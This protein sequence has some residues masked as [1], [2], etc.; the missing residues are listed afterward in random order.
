MVLIGSV[1][2]LVQEIVTPNL[3]I[4]IGGAALF[5]KP[6]EIVREIIRQEIKDLTI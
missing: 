1:N 5:L 6:M 2:E 4:A 3:K